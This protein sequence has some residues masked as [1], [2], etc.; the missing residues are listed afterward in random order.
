MFL[1]KKALFFKKNHLKQSIH[2]GEQFCNL[3]NYDTN[4]IS[5]TFFLYILPAF[6]NDLE[7]M[8]PN[9]IFAL[10]DSWIQIVQNEME[11]LFA[12]DRFWCDAIHNLA[13]VFNKFEIWFYI[14]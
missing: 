7:E 12:L 10:K 1:I 8:K 3:K 13:C 2:C 6:C 11:N 9:K 5:N 14:W 4:F